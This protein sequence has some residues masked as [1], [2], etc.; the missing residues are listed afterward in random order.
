MESMDAK[1]FMSRLVKSSKQKAKLK[2][3]PLCGKEQTSFCNS[4]SIPQFV[5]NNIAVN[6]K[7]LQFAALAAY[8]PMIEENLVDIEKGIKIPVHFN[9][10]VE[11]VIASFFLTMKMKFPYVSFPHGG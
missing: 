6:G 5:L 8:K 3:C 2:V 9:L 11:S 4:H 7:L 10:F 1:K